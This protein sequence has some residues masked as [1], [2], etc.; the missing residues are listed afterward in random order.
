MTQEQIDRILKNGG[1]L[2]Y[3]YSMITNDIYQLFTKN[4]RDNYILSE[5]DFICALDRHDDNL[6]RSIVF[7]S[8]IYKVYKLK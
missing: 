1:R 3:S 6:I 5:Q 7:N 8:G 4:N 2:V